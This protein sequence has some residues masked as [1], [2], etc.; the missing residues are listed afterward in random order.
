M[1]W[2]KARCK[3]DS[4]FRIRG[5]LVQTRCKVQ[6]RFRSFWGGLVQARCKV[7]G[8]LWRFWWCGPGVRFKQGSG[9]ALRQSAKKRT[10]CCW[11]YHL[12]LFFHSF[13]L[14]ANVAFWFLSCPR[15]CAAHSS[16]EHDRCSGVRS[17][18]AAPRGFHRG[19][20]TQC[21]RYL[22]TNERIRVSEH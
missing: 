4:R 1:V 10:A 19:C 16:Q 6:G 17:P 5:G 11:G 14:P 7:E 9:A 15:R 18:R 13:P 22:V 12:S 21:L 20:L 3:V 8:R 2:C